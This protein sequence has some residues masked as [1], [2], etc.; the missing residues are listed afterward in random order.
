MAM[1]PH[2]SP[3]MPPSYDDSSTPCL[4]GELADLIIVTAIRATT[5]LNR[6]M[7]APRLIALLNVRDP[8]HV[9]PNPIKAALMQM[10][11]IDLDAVSLNPDLPIWLLDM[12]LS[13]IPHR[14]LQYS[15]WVLERV[16]RLGRVDV[17][18]WWFAHHYS[19][20]G[21]LFFE[22]DP[23]ADLT[24][25]GFLVV[26]EENGRCGDSAAEAALKWC[27][28]HACGIDLDSVSSPIP[29]DE[30]PKM[31]NAVTAV[32]ES[33]IACG[34]MQATLDQIAVLL[35]PE[36]LAPGGLGWHYA[37]KRRDWGALEW[38]KRHARI[39]SEDELEMVPAN[40]FASGDRRFV[41]WCLELVQQHVVSDIGA[42]YWL[43]SASGFGSVEYLEWCFEMVLEAVPQSVERC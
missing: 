24:D 34:G 39:P 32:M 8:R 43:T 1:N 18:D 3:Q 40:C 2:D 26:G 27:F 19:I 6:S 33:L 14:P 38:L 7:D 12:Q 5:T 41:E 35:G 13:L 9:Y 42:G 20:D 36:Q 30:L 22:Y 28:R 31:Q 10:W 17:L 16:M 21:P 25:S 29:F 4:P 23:I 11:W 15:R 37:C